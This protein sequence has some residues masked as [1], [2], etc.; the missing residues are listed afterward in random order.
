MDPST[1]KL[2]PETFRKAQQQIVDRMGDI[3]I[4][5]ESVHFLGLGDLNLPGE[6]SVP[7]EIAQVIKDRWHCATMSIERCD[8]LEALWA[9]VKDWRIGYNRAFTEAC[10]KLRK[11]EADPRDIDPRNQADGCV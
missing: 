5:P 6:A 8:A 7:P 1:A 2:T 10:E 9:A 3:E 4:P 11:L